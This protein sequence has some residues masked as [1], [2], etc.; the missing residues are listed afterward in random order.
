M[1]DQEKKRCE[2]CGSTITKRDRDSTKQWTER[3]FCSKQ[4]ADKSRDKKAI[5]DRFW[6]FVEISRNGCWE[7]SGSTDDKG[8]GQISS[9]RGS[10]P[11]KAHRL[12]WEIHF[13]D[14]S[15][16]LNV[17]HA[18]DNPKCVNP[19]HLMLG[20]QVANMIDA[21]RKG[22]LSSEAILNL[23]P[24]RKGFHGA[25]PKSNKEISNGID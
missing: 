5:D 16:G 1:I 11:V 7:W 25:G 18:C 6:M 15:D 2:C 20:T 24:G 9:G 10:S 21:A 14:I 13:G 3:R 17:C 4:C 23:H 8:Y 22:R 12:S 19:D